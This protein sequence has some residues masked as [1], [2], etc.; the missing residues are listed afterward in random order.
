MWLAPSPSPKST[1]NNVVH[2]VVVVKPHRR[3]VLDV[4]EPVFL[5]LPLGC[6][7]RFSTNG[8]TE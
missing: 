5:N 8:I 7:T 6:K 3:A 1:G 4:D 2:A